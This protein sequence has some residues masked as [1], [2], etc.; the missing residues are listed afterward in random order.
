MQ[1][2][3]ASLYPVQSLQEADDSEQLHL[4]QV[5]TYSNADAEVKMP[6]SNMFIPITTTW[7]YM[8][9]SYVLP[10]CKELVVKCPPSCQHSFTNNCKG[11]GNLASAFK[12]PLFSI[13][14]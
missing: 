4:K 3:Y 14:P 9:A 6:I 12:K 10:L 8:R 1:T 13:P 7:E 2:H 5:E 11:M